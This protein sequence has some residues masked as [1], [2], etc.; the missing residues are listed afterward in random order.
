MDNVE[1]ITFPFVPIAEW[2][3]TRPYTAPGLFAYRH[4]QALNLLDFPDFGDGDMTREQRR[5]ALDRHINIKRPLTGIVIFLNVVALEDF[6]R[7]F[8][9]RLSN[10]ENLDKHY[11]KISVLGMTPQKANPQKPSKQLDKDPAPLMDFDKLNELYESC[12]GI[13]PIGQADFPRLY[14]LT[15][16]RHCIAHNGSIIREVDLPRFQYFNVTANQIINPPID[17]VK[18]TCHFLFTVGRRFENKIRDEI[19]K[20]VIP[21]LNNDWTVNKPK[22]ITDLIH[23]F[24]YFNKVP[25]SEN[26]YSED[27]EL[28]QKENEKRFNELIN[29]CILDLIELCG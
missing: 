2:S 9:M 22:I 1:K 18:E 4:I 16:I 15:I 13:K 12:I 26:F 3:V 11:P 5:E 21:S 24:N 28:I 8:G 19:F 29:L 20:R 17:F 10:I 14:D 7:D 6:I 23:L 27:P 25:I